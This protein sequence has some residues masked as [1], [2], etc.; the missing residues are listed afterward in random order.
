MNEQNTVPHPDGSQFFGESTGDFALNL[1]LDDGLKKE[2]LSYEDIE[3]VKGDRQNQTASFN[4]E[5]NGP[6]VPADIKA[7]MNSVS[8]VTAV[9][10][11]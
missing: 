3:E 7:E 6:Q 9:D 5:A 1:Q 8:E 4:K 11:L 2:Y 10:V